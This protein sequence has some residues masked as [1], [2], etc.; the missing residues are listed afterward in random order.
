MLGWVWRVARRA[1]IASHRRRRGRAS[2][3][4]WGALQVSL[5]VIVLA[6]HVRR[7]TTGAA[8]LLGRVGVV[9]TT[10][11]LWCGHRLRVLVV[12]IGSLVGHCSLRHVCALRTGGDHVH[13]HRNLHV[14]LRSVLDHLRLLHV[15]LLGV[16]RHVLGHLL[17]RLELLLLGLLLRHHIH[18]VAAGVH[19]HLHLHR[20]AHAW[21]AHILHLHHGRV[22]HSCIHL[23][24]SEFHRNIGTV[25][26]EHWLLVHKSARYN[27][28]R[29]IN[30]SEQ[31]KWDA[32]RAQEMFYLCCC[33]GWLLCMMR[34]CWNTICGGWPGAANICC[35]G[36]CCGCCCWR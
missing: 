4:R 2:R 18:R 21:S 27:K 8:V 15:D 26:H 5:V 1:V 34:C 24:G 11:V 33:G 22:H 25:L 35:C 17:E 20:R 3:W 7:A 31:L 16:L 6:L 36:G 30:V 13:L 9:R 12:D 28:Q 29:N 19:L 10:G 14:P 23:V 32:K